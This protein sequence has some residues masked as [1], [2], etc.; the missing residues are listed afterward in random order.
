MSRHFL[1]P[2][3]YEQFRLFKSHCLRRSSDH[4]SQ[5]KKNT[6]SKIY[7]Q[8]TSDK[9]SGIMDTS[10][11]NQQSCKQTSCNKNDSKKPNAS[12]LSGAWLSPSLPFVP[13][14]LRPKCSW[15]IALPLSGL[16]KGLHL[17]NFQRD[18]KRV[19]G[20]D[21]MINDLYEYSLQM[22]REI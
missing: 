13:C 3:V 17:R 7:L 21:V 16:W 11:K 20:T 4:I 19:Q 22:C 10:W 1:P 18:D 15:R 14:L 12:S 8:K 2:E 5:Y 9:S 6:S